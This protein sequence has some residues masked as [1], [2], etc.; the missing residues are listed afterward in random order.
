MPLLTLPTFSPS[1]PCQPRLSNSVWSRMRAIKR[2][3]LSGISFITMA[4]ITNAL[5]LLEGVSFGLPNVPSEILG[6]RL[7]NLFN[8]PWH[9][10]SCP[11]QSRTRIHAGKRPCIAASKL[12]L[13]NWEANYQVSDLLLTARLLLPAASCANQAPASRASTFPAAY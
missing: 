8:S 10:H 12:L 2:Y 1:T 13:C 4:P 3:R 7:E 9:T 6:Y 5:F 11:D